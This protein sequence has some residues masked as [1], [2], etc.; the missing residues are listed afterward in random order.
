MA[1]KEY[2][3]P[4]FPDR[5]EP[6]KIKPVYKSRKD[7]NKLVQEQLQFFRKYEK[8]E[9]TR[10]FTRRYDYDGALIRR[11]TDT[12]LDSIEQTLT[13]DDE[14]Q[15]VIAV[16][17]DGYEFS[18]WEKDGEPCSTII[19]FAAVVSASRLRTS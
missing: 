17:S 5:V 7:W 3:I 8:R 16:A 11:R 4:G 10:G 2:F 18:S 13:A 19:S 1:K 14:V 6:P 15:A 12:L 9:G